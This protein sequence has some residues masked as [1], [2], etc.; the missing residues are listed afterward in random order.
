MKDDPDA[1]VDFGQLRQYGNIL[2]NRQSHSTVLR[3]YHQPE[4]FMLPELR[5]EILFG[6]EPRFG[7][8]F[9]QGVQFLPNESKY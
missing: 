2:G 6:N 1:P 5:K 7:Y 3:R 9:L 4:E 8:L